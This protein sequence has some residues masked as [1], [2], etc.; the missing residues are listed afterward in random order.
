MKWAV[1]YQ[2]Y[3]RCTCV[4]I[5]AYLIEAENE[6]KMIQSIIEKHWLGDSELTGQEA[7]NSIHNNNG[8]GTDCI[9]SIVDVTNE[10]II[11]IFQQGWI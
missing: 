3:D 1:T 5:T 4:Q 2:E 11:Y 8:K 6:D 7:K 9:S 10:K